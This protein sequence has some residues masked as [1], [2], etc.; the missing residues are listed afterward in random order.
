MTRLQEEYETATTLLEEGL[1]LARATGYTFVA[2]ATL[3]HLGMIAA[4]V[5]E[6][7]M[8]AWRFR[9][10]PDVRAP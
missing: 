6:D 9:A 4:D 8:T 2:A 7:Y 5:Q 10:R 1:S 3:H